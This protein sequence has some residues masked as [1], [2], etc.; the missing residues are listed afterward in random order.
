MSHSNTKKSIALRLAMLSFM[1]TALLS[2]C[3][4][5]GQ[6]ATV[7]GDD[8][9]SS[10]AF[11]KPMNAQV[12]EGLSQGLKLEFS[13]F[14]LLIPANGSRGENHIDLTSASAQIRLE[15]LSLHGL[16]LSLDAPIDYNGLER[17]LSLTL[18]HDNLYF[19]L[20]ADRDDAVNYD[21][22]YHTLV[23][24]YDSGDGIDD[25]TQGI[26][27]YEYGDLDYVIAEILSV[28]GIDEISLSLDKGIGVT[29]DWDA[30]NDSI[31]A[32]TEYDATRFLW[33]LPIGENVYRLG[34]VHDNEGILSAIEFPLI[35]N[36]PTYATL[37]EDFQ[38]KFKAEIVSDHNLSW[39][40]RYAENEYTD[41]IDSL[42]LFREIAKL[43]EKKAF[44]L[45]ADFNITHTEDEIIGDEEHFATEAVDESA[46]LTLDGQID[47]SKSFFGGINAEL[48]LG[49][50]GGQEKSIAIH[51][52][53]TET[54]GNMNVFLNVNDI[55]KVQTTTDVCD[56]LISSIKDALGD[57]SI[58]ND[59]IMELLAS[60]LS[61][62]TGITKAIDAVKESSFYENIDKKHFEDI[63]STIVDLQVSDNLISITVDLTAAS[64]IG[65]AT[66]LLNG[67]TEHMSLGKII[68]DNVGLRSTNDSHTT[69]IIDGELDINPFET[70]EFD[71]SGY[72]EMTHLPH[73]AEEISAIAEHDQLQA[74]LDGYAL[75]QGTTS[76]ITS[77]TANAYVYDPVAKRGRTEQ[78]MA[79]HGS[80]AFDLVN[81]IGTGSMTFLDLKEN[82]INDHNLKIDLTGEAGENDTDQN[83]MNGTGN[84]NAMF[85]EYNSQN[86]TATSG[87]SAYNSENRS[88]PSH[89]PLKG[90]FSIHSLN[91]LLDV[92]LE[93]TES[94]DP[95]FERLTNL[96]SGIMA[97]TLLTKLLDGQYFELLSSKIL[98]SVEIAPDHS[99]FVIAPGIIQQNSG[100]TIKLG[101][102]GDNIP[103]TIEVWMTLE[104][105]EH[106]TEVYAKITLGATS[107]D[108]FPYQ[109]SS[110]AESEFGDYSS[111]K[112][113]LEFALGTITLG[114]TDNS[115][116][117]TYHL[118]GTINLRILTTDYP[119]SID[120]FIYL[121]GTDVKI[122]G[123]LYM[124]E[125]KPLGLVAVTEADTYVNFY[126]ETDGG[127]TA[128]DLFL[129][130]IT[131]EKNTLSSDKTETSHRR[132][133]GDDFAS[134]LLEWLMNYILN[135]GSIVTG[136]LDTSSSSKQSLHGED[137]IRG[138][139]VSG[140]V[141]N[142]TWN[143]VVGMEGLTHLS[144]FK[145]MTLTI[146]GK[147]ATYSEGGK[148]YQKKSL[149]S[150]GG[151]L[152]ISL[153]GISAAS[154]TIDLS[155]KNISSSGAY[156]DGWSSSSHKATIYQG[157]NHTTEG[158]LI[159]RDKYSIKTGSAIPSV[160]FVD[161]TYGKTTAN[162]TYRNCAYYVRPDVL[163]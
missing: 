106:D 140:T 84:Q 46:Y 60:L 41:I 21:L 34:L 145:D 155:I 132:V 119:I 114:V 77:T 58:Q 32:I 146:K 9:S 86:V 104:G 5:S 109:F 102:D 63:L 96:V 6:K 156:S 65:Q 154:A 61:T 51:S 129:R 138:W 159:K 82:F 59:M 43:A 147:T 85:F 107:F 44:G 36:T 143:V 73:W 10:V 37:N 15:N 91:G 23:A 127:D 68:L 89:D 121:N 105:E 153:I 56:A 35:E 161:S 42:S 11:A 48:V 94:T 29:F 98:T 47:L 13:M 128:G 2:S 118:G 131:I 33:E 66:V 99:T 55:L 50:T 158:W 149:Y 17:E 62:F 3:A 1:T 124:P 78:G 39:A 14:D 4:V 123:S 16:D 38:L 115:S 110:H 40:P 152:D 7:T 130:R 25:T 151:S 95:R 142:P 103:S 125:V 76:K 157:T 70:V 120:V 113:L 100:L 24:P 18:Y 83:D 101:Y 75:K 81:R 97:E 69:F 49:Q 57:E 72:S 160:A 162:S 79:F 163:A 52:K 54:E 136:N 93:L 134:N 150:L 31:D 8:E 20:S 108:S 19:S 133:H 71:E 30:I 80:L 74:Q 112:K 122:M 90:R 26:S 27:Y 141:D 144:I 12:L 53:D 22:K 135:M 139:S 28:C 148:A 116:V 92:I 117:T 64:L 111:I 87:S 126:Y 88:E 67:T 45:S 137:L